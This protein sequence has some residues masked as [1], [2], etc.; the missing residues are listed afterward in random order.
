VPRCIFVHNRPGRGRGWAITLE[1]RSRVRGRARIGPHHQNAGRR[2]KFLLAV[3][4]GT[5]R[6]LSARHPARHAATFRMACPQGR[7]SLFPPTR[8]ANYRDARSPEKRETVRNNSN[9]LGDRVLRNGAS[10]RAAMDVSGA[11]APHQE[12]R[13]CWL[14]DVGRSSWLTCPGS[15]PRATDAGRRLLRSF[16]ATPRSVND[17][18]RILARRLRC[19]SWA[20]N[21][22][23]ISGGGE[24]PS[25]RHI[26]LHEGVDGVPLPAPSGSSGGPPGTQGPASRNPPPPRLGPSFF[27]PADRR[28]RRPAAAASLVQPDNPQTHHWE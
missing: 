8:Y 25:W 9:R 19:S 23:P 24:P 14:N 13:G 6:R 1:L 18:Q 7:R 20:R 10:R 2:T 17:V 11:A 21:R 12:F 15:M 4:K 3:K 22:F 5:S 26:A 16:A 28:S 27:R